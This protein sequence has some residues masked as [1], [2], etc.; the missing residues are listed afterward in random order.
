MSS[1]HPDGFHAVMA[2]GT[3]RFISYWTGAEGL[4]GLSTIDG[5]ETVDAFR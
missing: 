3:V 5:G 4:R 1:D 2:D